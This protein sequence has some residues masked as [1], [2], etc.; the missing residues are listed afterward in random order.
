MAP[1]RCFY[2][3]RWYAVHPKLWGRQKTCGNAKC[4]ARHKA[5]LNRKWRKEHSER[6]KGRDKAVADRRRRERYWD[7]RRSK[8]PCYVQRNRKQTR[9]RMK[10]LRAQRKVTGQILSDPVGYLD[11][12]KEE[13]PK[14]FATQESIGGFCRRKEAPRPTVF[15][16]Q[17]PIGAFSVGLWNYL[18]ARAMFATQEEVATA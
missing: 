15:A 6:Q 3:G 2:C 17:E 11:G 12:L 13:N 10:R 16:T 1:E 7:K 14:M 5:A 4:R 9:E 8:D 18:K